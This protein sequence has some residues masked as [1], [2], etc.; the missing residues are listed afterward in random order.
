MLCWMQLNIGVGQRRKLDLKSKEA[1]HDF[2]E[3]ETAAEGYMTYL[4]KKVGDYKGQADYWRSH[5]I[6]LTK[7]NQTGA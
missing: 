2:K 4:E 6:Q 1:F 7:E 5:V 3:A